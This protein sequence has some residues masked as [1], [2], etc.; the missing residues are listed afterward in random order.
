MAGEFGD[1]ISMD[2]GD[3]GGT[4]WDNY[5]WS[6]L[7]ADPNTDLF[8]GGDLNA[9][10]AGFP[11]SGAGEQ[12]Y[13]D[14]VTGQFVTLAQA[15]QI[16]PSFQGVGGYGGTSD[17]LG[18]GGSAA[19]GPYGYGGTSNTSE[20]IS[21]AQLSGW[22]RALG[23]APGA[24]S[25]ALGLGTLGA[26]GAALFGGGNRPGTATQ[27]NTTTPS[28]LNSPQ[29]Q[30][31]LGTPGGPAGG[32]GG[33]YTGGTGL[34]GAAGQAANALQGPQGL[35]Q[36]Q[37]GAIP[38]LNP[39][40]QAAIGQNALGFSRGDVPTLNNPQAQQYFQNVLG[41]QNAAV[42]Y[43]TGNSLEAALQ[44]LRA[45]GF[46]G[47]SEIFREGAPA[48]AMGPV[49]AQGNAQ[50]SMNLGNINAQ[51]LAYAAQLP[52]WGSQLNTQQL[53]QQGV[54]FSAYT[55]AAQTQGGL[56]LDLLRA[57]MGQGGS[58]STQTSTGAPPNFLQTLGQIVP[59]LG[60]AGGALNAPSVTGGTQFGIGANGMYST[61]TPS[62]YSQ[63]AGLFGSG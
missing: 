26:A 35:L 18:S 16:D 7:F 17:V 43:Q 37:I 46:A 63:V 25:A 13:Y 21:P 54:P 57:L 5:D 9:L 15:Q 53:G 55:T 52:L 58:T 49:V 40:I 19:T 10:M 6:S 30:Q 51:Q 22:E 61:T 29:V 23:M 38:Q 24:L 1:L 60:A 32:P 59:L 36:G 33:A 62:L 34:Q 11:T 27:T 41:G 20:A 56:P 42:D 44:Q 47:G 8:Q 4:N 39:A 50:K 48:A 3:L 14:N 45:R 12:M 28:A 2:Y 31:L